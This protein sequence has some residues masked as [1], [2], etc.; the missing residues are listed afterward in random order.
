VL[1]AGFCHRLFQRGEGT[2]QDVDFAKRHR[3]K[4]DWVVWLIIALAKRNN[5][6]P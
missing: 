6:P 1:L 4:L 2:C 5:E 3:M